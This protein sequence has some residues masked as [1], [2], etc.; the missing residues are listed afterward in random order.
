MERC[1]A[2][3]GALA[4][5]LLIWENSCSVHVAPVGAAGG[6]D[7]KDKGKQMADTHAEKKKRGGHICKDGYE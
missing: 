3:T 5:S 6:G 2:D 1:V 7:Q 4:L